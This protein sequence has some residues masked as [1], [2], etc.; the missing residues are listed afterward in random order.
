[1]GR[2]PAFEEIREGGARVIDHHTVAVVSIVG[3]SLDVLGSA[4]VPATLLV[5]GCLGKKRGES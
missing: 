5:P 4:F 2:A 1:M 3:T